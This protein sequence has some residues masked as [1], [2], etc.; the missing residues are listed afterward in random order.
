MQDMPA[1]EII[2]ASGL[3]F[4]WWQKVRS[5]VLQ[6]QEAAQWHASVSANTAQL[7]T[8][9]ILRFTQQCQAVCRSACWQQEW[10]ADMVS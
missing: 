9:A 8:T 3:A 4:L 2:R 6:S 1:S 5:C 7:G 10:R